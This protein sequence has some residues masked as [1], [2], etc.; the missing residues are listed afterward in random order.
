MCMESPQ[1][2]SLTTTACTTAAAGTARH[3]RLPTAT[4]SLEWDCSPLFD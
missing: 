1:E 3:L 4:P 2:A